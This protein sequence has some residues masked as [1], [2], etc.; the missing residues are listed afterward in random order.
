MICTLSRPR[1]LERCLQAVGR[2]APAAD[3]VIVVDNTG[4][5]PPTAAVAAKMGA[6][7]VRE[8][9]RG[10]SR[11]RNAGAV[12]ATGDIVVFV[13]DDAVPTTN[14]LDGYLRAFSDPSVSAATGRFVGLTS[15]AHAAEDFGAA[16]RRWDRF[17]PGWFEQANFGGI[18]IGAN[19]A[20]H[21]RLFEEGFR[22]CE[23]LGAGTA[24]PGNEEHYAFFELLRDGHGVV[25]V[26]EA[27]VHHDDGPDP[28]A[29]RARE[30]RTLE[31]SLAYAIALLVQEPGFRGRTLR[32]FA[33]SRRNRRREW[34]PP[35]SPGAAERADVP[36]AALL[37]AP[38][39]YLAARLTSGS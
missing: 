33:G 36:L 7:L 28:A 2:L 10:L 37:R 14:W 25:Y 29:S 5:V 30:R 20:F 4:G 8:P 16:P 32:Y 21:R 39:R 31:A 24:V 19:M 34:R 26:P 35:L 12:A 17:T 3:E 18:G 23:W 1:E 9:R 38:V 11:A 27:V 15:R 22:F 6:R 13:D